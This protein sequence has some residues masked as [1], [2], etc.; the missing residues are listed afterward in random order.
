MDKPV[1]IIRLSASSIEEREELL[2]R[3]EVLLEAIRTSM[4]TDTEKSKSSSSC[5]F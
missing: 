2:K 5:E 1:S 4:S 3:V